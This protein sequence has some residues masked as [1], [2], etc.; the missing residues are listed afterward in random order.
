M[1]LTPLLLAA[2]AAAGWGA[3]DFLG[4][5]SSDQTAVF[6]VIAISEMLGAALI[7]PTLLAR[8]APLS[9]APLL[10]A[11]LAGISVTVELGVI[12]Y[13]L[14][15]GAAYITAPVGALGAT[16]TV[17][18]GLLEG[19]AITPA[20]ATGLTCALL[21]GAISATGDTS[22]DAPPGL[23]RSA[24]ACVLAA[25]AVATTQIT[26]HA[27]AKVN[28]YWATETEHLTTAVC[29]TAIAVAITARAR[30]TPR[31]ISPIRHIPAHTQLPILAL[32]AATGTSGDLAYAAASHGALSTI[33]AVSSLYPI[34]TIGLAL[35]LQHHHPRRLQLAGIGLALAGAVILG[36]AAP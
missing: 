31:L 9:G 24:A 5:W 21:G 14:S 25:M 11:A 17:T 28:P 32:V 2:V 20:I 27:A 36:A 8:P 15:V 10:L 19:D 4:G 12:F 22:N 3:S 18:V 29:A 35:A 30:R 16:F 26:L 6:S 34:P 23:I 1:S 33:S 7:A 13:A